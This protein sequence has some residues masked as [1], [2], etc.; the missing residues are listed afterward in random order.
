[1]LNMM[2]VMFGISI[3]PFQGFW[4]VAS[5]LHRASPCVSIRRA[6]RCVSIRRASPC[7]R[8]LSPFRAMLHSEEEALCTY[9]ACSPPK[10]RYAYMPGHEVAIY[11]NDGCSPSKFRYAHVP[12][13]EVALYTNDGCSPS[14]IRYVY[15]AASS[16]HRASPFITI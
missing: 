10:F 6:S 3:T 16:P 2:S 15:S 9:D 1:M 14:K 13:H 12:G 11:T 7:V 5:A 4:F 8:I